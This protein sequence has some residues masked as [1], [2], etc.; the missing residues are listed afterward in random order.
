[1]NIENCTLIIDHLSYELW[2]KK[3]WVMSYELRSYE[4]WVNDLAWNRLTFLNEYS[5]VFFF[6]FPSLS[7]KY[8]IRNF[9]HLIFNLARKY[10]LRTYEHWKLYID[11]WSFEFRVMS[12]ELRVKKLWVKVMKLRILT[13]FNWNL[14]LAHAGYKFILQKKSWQSLQSF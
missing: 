3:L 2:V 4:L 10:H 11:Y 12:Y 14:A 8:S 6:L 13:I 9:Q 5:I 1:M 7:K